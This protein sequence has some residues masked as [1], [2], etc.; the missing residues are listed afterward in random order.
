MKLTNLSLSLLPRSTTSQQQSKSSGH[1]VI[2]L[3][4]SES[5]SGALCRDTIGTSCKTALVQNMPLCLHHFIQKNPAATV[6]VWLVPAEVRQQTLGANCFKSWG[7]TPPPHFL[8]KAYI[9]WFS[10]RVILPVL[11]QPIKSIWWFLCYL[12]NLLHYTA[13]HWST[14]K[15]T[16]AQIY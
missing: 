8:S 14:A 1:A 4:P 15:S 11:L 5:Y 10:N 9:K 3:C 16:A 13:I 7:N 6:R 12:G 2:F